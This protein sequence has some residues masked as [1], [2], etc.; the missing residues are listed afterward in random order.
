MIRRLL[1]LVLALGFA[2]CAVG[3]DY[4]RPKD[5]SPQVWRDTT[6][7][8]DSTIAN[9][10]WWEVFRD[11]V[12][13]RLVQTA[14]DENKDLKIATERIEEARAS[15]GFT[16]ADY[17][18]R[19]DLGVTAGGFGSDKPNGLFAG[20]L[21]LA[22][23]L[24]L[25]GRIQRATEAERALLFA[26]EEARRGVLISLVADVGRTYMNLRD[27]DR[28]LEIA[29]RTLVSRKEYLDLAR[30]R[31][32]GGVTSEKDWRQAEAE[33]HRTQ[34]FVFDFERLVRLNE[35]ELSILLGRNPGPMLR[36]RAINEQVVLPEVPAGIPSSILERRPDILQAEQ[37]LVA[38]NARIGEAKALLYPQ[39]SLTGSGGVQ[40]ST[41]G[42]LFSGPTVAWSLLGGLVQP[43]FNAGKNTARVEMTESQMRQTLY[44]YERSIQQA[45]REVEDGLISYQK[46]GQQRTS[47]RSRV[48]AEQQVLNLADMRYRGGT[49]SYLEVLDA[50]RSLFSAELDEVQSIGDQLRSMILLYKALG[51]GWSHENASAQD[52]TSSQK[53]K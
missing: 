8:Q 6:A 30:T 11:T 24:D 32:E 46:T 20:E 49:A 42:L 26:T 4:V 31:F 37:E 18:P 39:I 17:W 27:A 38:A 2:A 21:D 3:P 7:T 15:L 29:Q 13:Q 43:L 28:R 1:P 33:Y 5:E 9:V 50:Q 51:G 52:S 34:S 19:V 44:F 23:E 41:L 48:L 35:N 14:L 53:T 25:F 12:L 16:K 47:Q 10:V 45:F 40:S 36:G 22:W